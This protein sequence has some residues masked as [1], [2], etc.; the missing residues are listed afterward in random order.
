MF[1]K[2]ADI[3]L[4]KISVHFY[5]NRYFV[6]RYHKRIGVEIHEKRQSEALHDEIRHK[7]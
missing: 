3:F 6:A 7:L 4:L 1:L 2:I 5:Y